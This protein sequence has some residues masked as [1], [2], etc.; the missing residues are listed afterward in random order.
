MEEKASV[1]LTETLNT[2]HLVT[3]SVNG[4]VKGKVNHAPQESMGGAHLPLLVLEPVR[5]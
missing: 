5:G 2:Q 1:E 3:V 4:K